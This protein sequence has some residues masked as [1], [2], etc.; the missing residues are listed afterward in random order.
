[1]REMRKAAVFIL[2][3]YVFTLPNLSEASA[4]RPPM[5]QSKCPSGS[6]TEV[7]SDKS[8][9]LTGDTKQSEAE[10]FLNASIYCPNA[11]YNLRATLV[12]TYTNMQVG[13]SA[14]NVCASA[15][16]APNDPTQ[17]PP[18]GCGAGEQKPQITI[19][20]KDVYSNAYG[21]HVP[22][23]SV[24]RSR[25]DS[26]AINSSITDFFSG[27][28]QAKTNP[29]FAQSQ[30]IGALNNFGSEQ[31]IEFSAKSQP[32]VTATP[33][34][35]GGTDAGASAALLQA[36]GLSPEQAKTAAANNPDQVNTLLQCMAKQD[37][38]DS[39]TFTQTTAALGITVDKSYA[40]QVMANPDQYINAHD[41]NSPIVTTQ[42]GSS[43]TF[44]DQSGQNSLA[45]TLAPMC[46][47]LGGCGGVCAWSNGLT[48]RTNNPGAIVCSSVASRFGA[49]GCDAN[50]NTAIF[51]TAEAGVAAQAALLTQSSRYFGS[52]SNTIL[53]AFCNGYSTSN[54]SQYAAFIS[55]QTGIPMTQTIDPN[56]SQQIAAI[57]MASSRFENG[58]GVI[59]T[60]DQL[61]TGLLAAYGQGT[62]PAGTPG[63]TPSVVY[64]TSGG[65]R[66]TSPYDF[67]YQ[68][69][70]APSVAGTYGSP[71]G[72]AMPMGYSMP[73]S[74]QV[75]SRVPQTSTTQPVS[76]TTPVVQQVPMPA[77]LP[78]PVATIIVQP[79]LAIRG[80]TLIVSWSSLGVRT[81][82][83]CQ[84]S[85]S[86]TTI[87]QANAGSKRIQANIPGIVQFVLSCMSPSGTAIQQSAS[88]T[89]Q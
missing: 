84:V 63:Y 31:A 26:N 41:P 50:N 67:W 62:L 68:D 15:S 39:A 46:D 44:G 3:A 88:A 70:A 73:P 29:E 18:R 33:L 65:Y 1:M 59:Y 56:N 71:L 80:A 66:Y 49:V 22:D 75:A 13:I 34:P 27:L 74:Y 82:I 64:G 69:N 76:Q 86:S 8:I 4:L 38:C 78:A 6:S 7:G 12:L 89:V 52:G 57:M 16:K 81:D 60:P 45:Q 85:M 11:C 37:G 48:C 30:M 28:S 10:K 77:P 5:D 83:P 43:P 9:V 61:Q 72:N 25:C 54:C 21:F 14:K 35:A 42:P 17:S 32:D 40:E 58:R 23:Q 19:T 20:T 53:G 2:C 55:N 87:A 51:P 79:T 47:Q 36:F 24:T